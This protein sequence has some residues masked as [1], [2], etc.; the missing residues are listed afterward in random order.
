VLIFFIILWVRFDGEMCEG[1][2]FVFIRV[3]L[4]KCGGFEGLKMVRESHF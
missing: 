3:G 2:F 4:G 1:S